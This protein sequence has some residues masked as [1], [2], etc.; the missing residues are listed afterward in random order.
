M[1]PLAGVED[2]L[3]ACVLQV[4]NGGLVAHLTDPEDRANWLAIPEDQRRQW[5]AWMWPIEPIHY[6]GC[7]SPAALLFQNG[8]LDIYALPT[9]GLRYQEA[10]SEL[11]TVRWYRVGH[12]LVM[13]GAAYRDQAQWLSEM[14]G[15]SVGRLAVPV[16]PQVLAAYAG[17]YQSSN[18]PVICVDG[19]RIFL[20]VPNEPRSVE[21]ARDYELLAGSENNFHLVV[22][23]S[24]ITFYRN[25]SGEV[26][27]MVVGGG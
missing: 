3:K 24:E 9:D 22:L 5:V 26:D 14:I 12:N 23:D 15:I 16:D 18:G 4:S 2:H 21:F 19:T 17:R 13:D 20:Q 27:R 7:A 25:D 10:G 8:T 11:K 6:V 1:W